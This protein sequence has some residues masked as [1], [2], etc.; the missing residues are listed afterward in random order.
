V[1][2]LDKKK[3]T[4]IVFASHREYFLKNGD[5]YTLG[6]LGAETGENFRSVF[7]NMTVIGREGKSSSGASKANDYEY[8]L[9]KLRQ[10]S[11][12]LILDIVKAFST[13]SLIVTRSSGVIVRAGGV[14]T[15]VGLIA[16]YNKKPLGVE[17][18]GCV[19][20]SLWYYGGVQ[21]RVW[22]PFA[23]IIR[24]FLLSRANKVQMVTSSYLQSRYLSKNK[25]KLA[26]GISNVHIL[27]KNIN[28]LERRFVSERF[29]KE[30]VIGCVGSFN[31]RFKGYDIAIKVCSMLMDLGYTIKLK[32]LGSG[33][34]SN[35]KKLIAHH[36][37][38]DN[39]ELFQPVTPGLE[40]ERWLDTLDIYCQFSRREGI[41]RALI[42]AMSIG[43]PVVASNAG[44][45][46]ELVDKQSIFEL[47]DSKTACLKIEA[48]IN[49]R[50][51]FN[52]QCKKSYYKA[53][54]FNEDILSKRREAYWSNFIK[55]KV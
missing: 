35:V 15:F 6:S 18:G 9:I 36:G 12:L 2:C 41:S 53:A 19:F 28:I 44:G 10:R 49:N 52:D 27:K 39:V 23:Y 51:F 48:L 37:V 25:R 13:I 45:T 30:I 16:I 55:D 20:N 33:D 43:L 54:E 34:Q 24:R 31:G 46:Y 1:I 21:G 42:E 40:V 29:S 7:P 38:N 8:I 11:P 26:I 3:C 47:N 4:K 50:N 22:A 17:V 5:L 14:G 32:I